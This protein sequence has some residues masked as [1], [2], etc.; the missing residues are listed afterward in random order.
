MKPNGQTHPHR[1]LPK[2]TANKK[3]VANGSQGKVVS[4]SICCK[5][6]KASPTILDWAPKLERTGRS[7]GIGWNPRKNE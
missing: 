3:K 6:A 4:K 7:K 2:I 5:A 1:L